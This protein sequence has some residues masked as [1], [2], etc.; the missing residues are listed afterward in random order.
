[1][2]FRVYFNN[3]R[4][5][6]EVVLHDVSPSTFKRWSGTPWGYY[7]A[8]A[9]RKDRS[10]KFGEIHL[11]RERVRHDLAAHELFH[12]L[13]DWLGCKNMQIT[14]Q[15]EERLAGLFDEMI[16]NFWRAFERSKNG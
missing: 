8:A 2:N 14:S 11:V 1:M 4:Q 9:E 15:N 16:R 3:R 5:W 7:Q 13:A 10:G 12:V 6:L